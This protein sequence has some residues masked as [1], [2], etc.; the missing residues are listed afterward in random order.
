MSS[1]GMVDAAEVRHP[2]PALP[3]VGKGFCT[4]S[5]SG[6]LHQIFR[7]LDGVEGGPLEKLVAGCE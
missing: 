5:Y 4:S 1:R 7:N 2:N 3:F 6:N